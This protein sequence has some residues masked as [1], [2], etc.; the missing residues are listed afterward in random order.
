MMILTTLLTQFMDNSL[1]DIDVNVGPEPLVAAA[2]DKDTLLTRTPVSHP[3]ASRHPTS[4][5]SSTPGSDVLKSDKPKVKHESK[6]PSRV[7]SLAFKPS[8][9]T[10][11]PL[12]RSL[13][14]VFAEDSARDAELASVLANQKHAREMKRL[15]LKKAKLDHVS[16][17]QA[18]THEL[19]LVR[20]QTAMYEMQFRLQQGQFGGNQLMGTNMYGQNQGNFGG[21]VAPGYGAGRMG[22]GGPIAMG[23][24]VGNN[25]VIGGGNGHAEGVGEGVNVFGDG[26]G[27]GHAEAVNEGVNVF[28]DDAN[29]FG[30]QLDFNFDDVDVG[31]PLYIPGAN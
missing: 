9:T 2:S 23:G 6:P 10:T 13:H 26:G 25:G 20:A 15:E 30:D 1:R 12:K 17:A 21:V 24:G 4:S 14:D 29:V 28:G 22:S 19:E 31:A 18:R 5:A 16:Q 11:K 7:G 27:H 3:S 8:S